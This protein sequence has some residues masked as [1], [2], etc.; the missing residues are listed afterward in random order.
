MKG[1]VLGRWPLVLSMGAAIAVVAGLAWWDELREAQ[2][3]LLDIEIEQSTLAASLAGTLRARLDMLERAPRPDEGRAASSD[4]APDATGLGVAPLDLLGASARI[5]R[6]GELMLLLSIP[7]QTSFSTMTGRAVPSMP[8]RDAL[9]RGLTSLRLDRAESAAIGLPARTSMAGL[10]RLRADR[11]KSWAVV[12][13][14]SAARERDRERRAQHRLVLGV[15]VAAG[16]VVA[17]GGAALRRQRK[18]LELAGELAVAEV[19]RVRDEELARAARAA[20]TGTFAMGIAHEVSTPLGI[21]VGRAEQLLGRVRGDERAT[22]GAQVILQQALAIEQIVR[23]FLDMARGS[24]PS[25][26]EVDPS[27]VAA[28]AATAVEHRFVKAQVSLTTS[29][30]PKRDRVRCDRALLE[31]AIVNLLLNACDACVP[32]GHVELAL[33][34]TA[35]RVAFVVTDDGSGISP[36]HAA[37][38]TEPFFTTKAESRG[39][40]L[41]LA[42]ASEIVKGHRGELSIAPNE[43]RGTRASI[44]IPVS[45]S[46]RHDGRA[47]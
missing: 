14:A 18:E 22:R 23:R 47:S 37:R 43:P 25:L 29:V 46:S 27:E 9:D 39:T 16:L 7:G 20:T 13:V 38:A 19:Q 28:R 11:R 41:G 44:E 2:A 24:P 4:E 1:R 10:A 15:I 42:I 17:F 33:S 6:P 31:H 8:L 32:G 5:E 36:E 45:P 34:S 26:E 21:I 3:A 12:A 30:P 35:S 40:G